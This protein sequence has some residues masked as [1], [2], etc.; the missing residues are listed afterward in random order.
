M[1]EKIKLN[2]L[3]YVTWIPTHANEILSLQEL[4][5]PRKAA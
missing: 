3:Q 2:K 4:Y 5:I 1:K